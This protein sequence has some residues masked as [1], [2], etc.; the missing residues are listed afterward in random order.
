MNMFYGQ[1]VRGGFRGRC[2]AG[3]RRSVRSQGFSSSGSPAWAVCRED[4]DRG[5]NQVFLHRHC[6]TGPRL[7]FREVLK[8][9]GGSDTDGLGRKSTCELASR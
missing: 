2:G 1:R 5:Y 3:D 4:G 7:G 6:S 9:L 8:T